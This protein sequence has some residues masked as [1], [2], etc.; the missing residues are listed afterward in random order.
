MFRQASQ[1]QAQNVSSLG[2]LP[3]VHPAMISTGS[4]SAGP[5]GSTSDG[6]K[7]SAGPSQS[8][9]PLPPLS[10]GCPS[11]ELDRKWSSQDL[12]QRKHGIKVSRA[13][14]TCCA[15]VPLESSTVAQKAKADSCYT[16]IP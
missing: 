3:R 4:W 10:C 11:R 15:T 5:A 9:G 12:N 1:D 14:L 16:G 2:N 6:H 7:A 13:E 8:Q